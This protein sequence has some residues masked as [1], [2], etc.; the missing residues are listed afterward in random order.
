MAGLARRKLSSARQLPAGRLDFE[1]QRNRP[2]CLLCIVGY[3]DVGYGRL[4]VF[5]DETDSCFLFGLE[6]SR[7]SRLNLGRLISNGDSRMLDMTWDT[8]TVRCS[9]GATGRADWVCPA[10]NSSRGFSDCKIW[11]AYRDGT[12]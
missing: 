8:W 2:G 3:L 10:T 1:R 11:A 7:Q 6:I 5:W 9:V 4:D 12:R